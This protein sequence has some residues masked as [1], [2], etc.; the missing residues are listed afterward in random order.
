MIDSIYDR[1]EHDDLLSPFFPGGVREED[2]R[3]VATWWCEV[4]GG[5]AAYTE[6][7]GGYEHMLH[8]HMLHKHLQL[9]ITGEQRFALR[10]S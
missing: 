5:P 8:E 4:F 2:R 10:R 9:S 7:L 6:Q 3:N 1:V